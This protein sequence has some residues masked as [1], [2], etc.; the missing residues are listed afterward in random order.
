MPSKIIQDLEAISKDDAV[1][2]AVGD[3]IQRMA[4]K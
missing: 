3:T 2:Y 4:K 1:A